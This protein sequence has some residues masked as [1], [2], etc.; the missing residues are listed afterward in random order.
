MCYALCIVFFRLN[1]M[2]SQSK[3]NL[4]VITGLSILCVACQSTPKNAPTKPQTPAPV[5]QQPSLPPVVPVQPTPSDS[6]ISYSK[7]TLVIFYN[8][9]FKGAVLSAIQQRQA[10]IIY[11]YNLM[12]GLAIRLNSKDNL[13]KALQEL[14]QVNG[15]LGVNKNQILTID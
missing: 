12:N 5:V 7:D 2:L 1:L 14:R 11:D 10:E 9:A 3:L 13:E 4:T 8:E 6:T 15:V